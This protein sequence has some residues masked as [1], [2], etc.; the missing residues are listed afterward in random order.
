MLRFVVVLVGCL[1]LGTSF[2]WTPNKFE[3]FCGQ[4]YSDAGATA[5]AALF[6]AIAVDIATEAQSLYPLSY[7]FYD[8]LKG[9]IDPDVEGNEDCVSDTRKAMIA[10]YAAEILPEFE[11][12]GFLSPSPKRLGP[13]VENDAGQDVVR[14]YAVEDYDGVASTRAPCSGNAFDDRRVSFMTFSSKKLDRAPTPQLYYILAHEMVHVIQNAQPYIHKADTDNC[15]ITSWLQDATADAIAVYLTHKRFPSYLPPVT[16]GIGKNI[17]GFRPV[18]KTFMWENDQFLPEYRSSSFWRYLAERYHKGTYNFISDYMFVPDLTTGTDDWLD[19]LNAVLRA[20]KDIQ[21]YTTGGLYRIYPDF[22]AQYAQWGTEKYPH[23]GEEAWLKGTFGGCETIILSPQQS[24]RGLNLSL[25]PLSGACI[26]VTVSGLAAGEYGAVKYMVY[27]STESA[28]DNLHLSTVYTTSNVLV[29]GEPFNCYELSKRYDTGNC[30]EKPFTG[31][32]AI[33]GDVNASGTNFVKT[34]LSLEQEGAN[35]TFENLMVLTHSPRYPKA[36]EHANHKKQNVRMVVG[37]EVSKLQTSAANANTTSAEG[38][39]QNLSASNGD[40]LGM[41][42][43]RGGE[44]GGIE[45]FSNLMDPEAMSQMMFLMPSMPFNMGEILAQEGIDGLV[46]ISIQSTTP[47][48]QEGA[49]EP[50]F[51]FTVIPANEDG[52]TPIPYGATG[53]YKGISMGMNVPDM[54]GGGA[55]TLENALSGLSNMYTPWPDDPPD[56]SGQIEVLEYSEDL[57][58][59]RV[60]GSVCQAST[61]TEEGCGNV[62]TFSGEIIK[63]FGWT[64]DM[65]QTFTSIDTPGME[66]YRQD[67]MN[68]LSQVSDLFQPIQPDGNNNP[69]SSN[70]SPGGNSSSN[71]SSAVVEE[72]TCECSCEEF[73]KFEEL[74]VEME[75]LPEDTPPSAEAMQLMQCMMP[76]MMQ[77]ATCSE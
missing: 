33:N 49:L 28:L 34:W 36:A 67:L 47:N 50:T 56:G 22:L 69:E 12:L 31:K 55:F 32:R 6:A 42:P 77:Y 68:S 70:N 15:D 16:T 23:V 26:R 63:P 74:S 10:Q 59:L 75:A 52:P 40:A 2:A 71:S 13:V 61:L 57:L 72:F 20:D 37:L 51:V 62:V 53:T 66:I 39:V 11:K 54:E 45:A 46:S 1:F 38:V 7:E 41:V 18:N 8:L 65:N 19:W 44:A 73:E 9:V 3:V 58:H 14:I 43:M 27:D 64:Y 30:T 29:L 60:S 35:G 76:C 25:E 5:S 24:T 48:M 21:S 17:H 4:P